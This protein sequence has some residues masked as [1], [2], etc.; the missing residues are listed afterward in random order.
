MAPGPCSQG[1]RK[2]LGTPGP[3]YIV[4]QQLLGF[5]TAQQGPLRWPC[6]S[7]LSAFLDSPRATPMVPVTPVLM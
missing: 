4:Q 5:G 2:A 1:E 3:L 6:S 7:S